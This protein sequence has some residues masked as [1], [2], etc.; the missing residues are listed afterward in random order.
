MQLFVCHEEFHNQQRRHS[1]VGLTASRQP[2]RRDAMGAHGDRT[3]SSAPCDVR[4]VILTARP[5]A[6]VHAQVPGG[7][8]AQEFGRHLDQVCGAA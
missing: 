2:I 4:E 5:V 8:V 1:A 7:R 3:V 6:G